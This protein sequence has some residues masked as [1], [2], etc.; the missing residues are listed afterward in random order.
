MWKHVL[1]QYTS[2]GIAQL[3][4]HINIHHPAFSPNT[5]GVSLRAEQQHL[6]TMNKHTNKKTPRCYFTVLY[7][8]AL[9]LTIY[10]MHHTSWRSYH[11]DV[12]MFEYP[13]E[14]WGESWAN[15]R[16]WNNGNLVLMSTPKP[17]W[18]APLSRV[19]TYAHPN[20]G[21]V[22]WMCRGLRTPHTYS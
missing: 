15:L 19:E 4:A 3:S 12:Y 14:G 6:N 7:C 22:S 21:V 1:D 10:D 5:S 2:V 18:F 8:T 11:L 16:V 20:H 13:Q 9:N 17:S